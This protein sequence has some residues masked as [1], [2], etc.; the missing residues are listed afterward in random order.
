[1]TSFLNDIGRSENSTKWILSTEK[2]QSGFLL[3][4][5][6]RICER[7]FDEALSLQLNNVMPVEKGQYLIQFSYING[8]TLIALFEVYSIKENDAFK[9]SSTLVLPASKYVPFSANKDDPKSA[10]KDA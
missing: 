4:E 2:L 3:S 8:S 6:E 7:Q 10:N 5:L 9:F 1:M